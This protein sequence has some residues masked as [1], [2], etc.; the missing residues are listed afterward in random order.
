[1]MEYLKRKLSKL[2]QTQT[3]QDKIQYPRYYEENGQFIKE[4]ENGEKLIVS[5]NENNEEIIIG[6]LK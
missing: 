5:L 6:K 2:N 1:M 4:T 3:W